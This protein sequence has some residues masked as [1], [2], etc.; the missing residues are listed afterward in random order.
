MRTSNL[1]TLF[2]L[3]IT[4][5]A[6]NVVRAEPG[7]AA[8]G[9]APAAGPPRIVF[10]STSYDFGRVKAGDPVEH[11]YV[12]TNT[13]TALLRITEVDPQCGCTT[14]KPWSREVAPGQVGQIPVQ[15]RTSGFN[16]SVR[17]TVTV[18]CSDPARPKTVLE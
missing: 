16:G 17:K 13:G 2:W 6:V 7:D 5:V 10:N 4:C 11:S 12:F 9:S 14:A 1:A 18:T 15:F 3:C 8:A